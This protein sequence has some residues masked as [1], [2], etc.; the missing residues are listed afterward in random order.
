VDQVKVPWVYRLALVAVCVQ[1]AA[2]VGF[3]GQA[4]GAFSYP[5]SALLGLPMLAS[6]PFNIGMIIVLSRAVRSRA[7]SRW[8][9]AAA[10]AIFAGWHV[11]GL[12]SLLHWWQSDYRLAYFIA[13]DRIASVVYQATMSA[14]FATAL[15]VILRPARA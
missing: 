4:P 11:Y 9:V 3:L 10:C 6:L 8:V 1:T 7:I 13:S 15:V 12:G 2:A 14:V 5:E